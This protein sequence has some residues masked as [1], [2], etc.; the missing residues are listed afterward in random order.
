[1]SREPE[2]GEAMV[3]DEIVSLLK[4]KGHG[5]LSMAADSKGYGIPISYG[6]DESENAVVMEFVT[7]ADT[8]KGAFIEATEEATLVVYNYEDRR[9]WESVLV[10][11]PVQPLDEETVSDRYS[12][13]FFS[14]ADDA[15]GPLRWAE[16]LAGDRQWYEL[17]AAEL[18]GRHG[19]QLPHAHADRSRE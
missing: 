12:A 13:L 18:T 9:T 15:A 16:E 17:Q 19:G 1:M 3:T 7:T 11:G 14:Q 10:T 4:S 2:I 5:V 8:K 6:Y